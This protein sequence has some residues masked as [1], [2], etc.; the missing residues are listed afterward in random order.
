MGK[1]C[2]PYKLHSWLQGG[3]LTP[4]LRLPRSGQSLVDFN[5]GTGMCCLRNLK[6]CSAN[7][8]DDYI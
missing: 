4:V 5:V 7:G 6:T 3:A 8:C 2:L 1:T